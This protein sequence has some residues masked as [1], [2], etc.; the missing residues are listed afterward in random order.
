MR[1]FKRG[2]IIIDRCDELFTTRYLILRER[3]DNFYCLDMKY[4]KP[5]TIGKL[6]ID[7]YSII[8]SMDEEKVISF[9]KEDQ[10]C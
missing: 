4:L 7:E 10:L 8:N 5:V 2:D 3:E 1:E 6:W 9:L